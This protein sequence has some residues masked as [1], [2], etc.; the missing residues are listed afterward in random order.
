MKS[1]DLIAARRY[2]AAFD[3]LNTSNDRASVC[4]SNLE[5]AAEALRPVRQYMLS[6]RVALATKK[7]LI[8]TCLQGQK[9]TADFICLL[10]EARQYYLLDEIVLRVKKLLDKRLGILQAEIV[11][12][13]PLTKKQQNLTLEVLSS[14]Y[15]AKVKGV[16]K[17]DKSLLGGL[18]I[19][20]R[21][22]QIDGSLQGRLKKLQEELTKQ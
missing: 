9:L 17:T 10:L 18:K 5:G 22:E 14:R 7:E 21:G 6:P 13:E 11:S 16:F 1:S 8:Q 19:T 15:G 3:A 20:C 4:F 2:A 12:A